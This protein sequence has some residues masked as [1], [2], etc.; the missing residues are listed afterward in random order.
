MFRSSYD[1]KKG[2]VDYALLQKLP[3]EYVK[4]TGYG[5]ESPLIVSFNFLLFLNPVYDISQWPNWFGE[6]WQKL[7]EEGLVNTHAKGSDALNLQKISKSNYDFQGVNGR[8]FLYIEL[9]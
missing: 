9:P 2:N 5:S 6:T 3:P 4:Y 7:Q 8:Y 1:K